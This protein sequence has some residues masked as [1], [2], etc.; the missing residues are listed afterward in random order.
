MS[1]APCGSATRLGAS[2]GACACDGQDAGSSGP[3]ACRK[4]VA[5]AGRRGS[6]QD[7]VAGSSAGAGAEK[8]GY[9]V[10]MLALDLDLEADLGID[11]VKQAE[12]FAAIRDG[13]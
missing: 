7:P 3:T 11:T 12:M 13:L 6:S 5:T 10:D 8:T 1:T 9:P 2:Y 4:P